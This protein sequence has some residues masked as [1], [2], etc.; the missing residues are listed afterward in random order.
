MQGELINFLPLQRGGLLEGGGIFEGGGG[1]GSIE[2][3]WYFTFKM[4]T[5]ACHFG[6]FLVISPCPALAVDSVISNFQYLV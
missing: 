2:D 4:T 6:L 5:P 3:L 1:G